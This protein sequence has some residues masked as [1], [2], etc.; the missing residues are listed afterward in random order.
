VI[1]CPTRYLDVIIVE[2]SGV[3]SGL[4]ISTYSH[5]LYISGNTT[6]ENSTLDGLKSSLVF[7]RL[8]N[9]FTS[10]MSEG[11]RDSTILISYKPADMIVLRITTTTPTAP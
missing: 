2:K 1:V 9:W 10:L 4:A 7:T 3:N 8:T 5:R 11:I 6:N